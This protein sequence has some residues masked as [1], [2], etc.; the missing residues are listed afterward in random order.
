MALIKCPECSKEVSDK[1]KT[2]PHC[3]YPLTNN[4]KTNTVLVNGTKYDIS[5]IKKQYDMISEENKQRLYKRAS[6]QYR[7]CLNPELIKKKTPEFGGDK[8]F[9]GGDITHEICKT[10]NWWEKNDKMHLT[11]K[12]F[13]ECV[14]HGFEYFEFN[15]DNYPIPIP[16]QS[17]AYQNVVHCPRCGSTSVTT[18]E[19][20]YGLFGWIGASQKKNLCQKCGHKWWPGR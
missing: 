8:S 18:E 19:K 20:G 7:C 9:F 3:G 15:T 1:A 4:E 10:F 13:V 14:N 11:Y 5:N 12:F 2:C 16:K 17:P 6:W